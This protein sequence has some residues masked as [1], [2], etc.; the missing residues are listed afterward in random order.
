M[1]K[2]LILLTLLV[3]LCVGQSGLLGLNSY[4]NATVVASAGFVGAVQGIESDQLNPSGIAMLSPQI[5]LSVIKYPANIYAQ[6]A[7]YLNNR[8]KDTYGI[9]IRRINYGSFNEI[10]ENGIF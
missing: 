4:Y 3:K 2:K 7:N 8:K 6:S 5:Q 10:D 1:M 9:A